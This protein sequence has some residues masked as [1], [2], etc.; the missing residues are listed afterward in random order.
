MAAAD[1]AMLAAVAAGSWGLKHVPGGNNARQGATCC[2][3]Y[4][5]SVTHLPM[6]NESRVAHRAQLSHPPRAPVL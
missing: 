1:P 3:E 4:R 6:T 2:V 5:C